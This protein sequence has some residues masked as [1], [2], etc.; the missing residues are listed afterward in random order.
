VGG[1]AAD[2]LDG[3]SGQ[4]VLDGRGG[5]DVLRGRDGVADR[6]VCGDGNDRAEADAADEVDPSCEVVERAEAPPGSDPNAPPGED[7]GPPVV[8]GGALTLQRGSRALRVMATASEPAQLAASGTVRV[9]GQRLAFAPAR[10]RVTVAGGGTTLRLRLSR[11]HRRLV[12]RALARGRRLTAVV[13]VVATDSA[14]NSSATRLPPIRL[15][16]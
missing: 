16:R 9:G 15:V 14:G 1:L 4:D 10:A 12:T 13:T 8:E 2:D 7:P 3:G 6:L 5:D 11:A